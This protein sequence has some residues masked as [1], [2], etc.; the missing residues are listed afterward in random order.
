MCFRSW[1]CSKGVRNALPLAHW[2][3]RIVR[4]QLVILQHALSA[5]AWT[6][7]V[8]NT[9]ANVS[10]SLVYIS[11]YFLSG[12]DCG[13]ILHVYSFVAVITRVSNALWNLLF[14]PIGFPYNNNNN[15]SNN[16]LFN[17]LIS[18]NNLC[19]LSSA[20]NSNTL[21]VKMILK[22]LRVASKL[23][24]KE[25]K[26]KGALNFIRQFIWS[27][28][29]KCV[30][31]AIIMWIAFEKRL[32]N[33]TDAHEKL[34]EEHRN[35]NVSWIMFYRQTAGFTIVCKAYQFQYKKLPLR[36]AL[37]TAFITCKRIEFA[38]T[39]WKSLFYSSICLGVYMVYVN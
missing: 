36:A 5:S 39:L 33:V 32:W 19:K 22:M 8:G 21:S 20:K 2:R 16:G 35:R 25:S 1:C 26:D 31:Y 9:S 12:N 15:D 27:I 17:I 7:R 34:F 37:F 4:H 11:N 23:N 38:Q 24:P 18:S 6:C 30:G 14:S 28:L 10:I 29:Q 3:V 13:Y